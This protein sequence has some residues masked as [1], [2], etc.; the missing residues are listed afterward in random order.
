MNSA[1]PFRLIVTPAIASALLATALVFRSAATARD[2]TSASSPP[3]SAGRPTEQ[4]VVCFGTVD[5]ENGTTSVGPLQ[6]GRVAEILVREN[7]VV[8]EG[9]EL[10]RLDDAGPRSRLAEA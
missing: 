10:L 4:G 8:P 7:Q 9:T 1:A 6:P 3:H 2:A 5:L